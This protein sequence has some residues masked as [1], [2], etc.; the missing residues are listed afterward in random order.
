MGLCVLKRICLERPCFP[1]IPCD[2]VAIPRSFRTAR[3]ATTSHHGRPC[4]ITFG[5]PGRPRHPPF[6][7]PEGREA[8]YPGSRKR[9]T[10]GGMDGRGFWIP[11]RVPPA[12]GRGNLA[13]MTKKREP[14]RNDSAPRHPGRLCHPP[15]VI[16]ESAKRLSG[17]QE[18]RQPQWHVL[19]RS[20]DSGSR[21]AR[22]E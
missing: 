21:C 4:P 11:A 1:C 8:D 5:Y 12:Q 19:A 10:H 7:I 6:V 14:I 20:L 3:S 9:C 22:P 13:G 18:K 15:F 16:P 2:S 17:I